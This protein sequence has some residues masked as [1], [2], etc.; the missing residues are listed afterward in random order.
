MTQ[1]REHPALG[2]L[3]AHLRFRFVFR[4]R[5]ARG[6]HDRPIVLR[7]LGVRAID[8]GFVSVRQRDAALQIVRLL[9]PLAF[10]SLPAASGS[11]TEAAP[12]AT[13]T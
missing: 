9:C 12:A 3:H 10:C 1:G 8:L 6:N 11:H 2:D 5:H 13:G 7:E 4:P